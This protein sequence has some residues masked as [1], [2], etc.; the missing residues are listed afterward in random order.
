MIRRILVGLLAMVAV[1]TTLLV[2]VWAGPATAQSTVALEAEPNPAPSGQTIRF[3]IEASGDRAVRLQVWISAV[4]VKRPGLGNLP[5]GQWNLVCC[6]GQ[7]AGDPAW[8]Y[9]S[10]F[11]AQDGRYAFRAVADRRGSHVATAAYGAATDCLVFRVA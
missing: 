2:G 7:T 10:E 1:A 11:P 4:G 5:P 8:H 6:P 9:R 3:T